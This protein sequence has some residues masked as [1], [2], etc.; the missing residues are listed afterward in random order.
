MKLIPFALLISLSPLL[1]GQT[2]ADPASMQVDLAEG[3]WQRGKN[4]YAAG[5][6][7]TDIE[8]RISYFTRAAQLF[9]EFQQR[10]PN[11]RE[12]RSAQ[13]YQAL[14]LYNSGNVDAA[15]AIFSEIITTQRTGPY[16]AAASSAMAGDAFEKKDYATAAA[17][18]AKLAANAVKPADRQRGH[19]FEALSHHYRQRER[20]ALT[21]YRKV[22]QDPDA[23]QSP[24]LHLCRNAV[25]ALLLK[26][27]KS[28]EAL[29]Y[30]EEI[31]RSAAPEKSRAEATFYAGVTCLQLQENARAE[32]Y[33]QQ[34]LSQSQ[35]DWQLYR[36]DALTSLMQ[37]RFQEKKY[38][39][40]VRLFRTHPLSTGDE[41]QAKRT[42]LAARSFMLIGSY[43]EAIPLFLDVQK[44]APDTKLA[45][46]ASYHRL[47]CFYQ[48]DGKHIVEQVDAF[49]EIY[50]KSHKS[51]PRLHAALMMK[52][53]A[54][55]NQGKLA[56]AAATY[57]LIDT[58]LIAENNRA[59]LQYQRGWCL[60]KVKNYQA[61]I[62]SLTQFISDHPQDKRR[63][64]AM[65]LRGDCYLESGDRESALKEFSQLIASEPGETLASY[66]WQK[67]AIVKKQNND[68]PGMIASYET[69]L[70]KFPSL[71]PA[72]VANAAFYIGYG[73]H[74][75]NQHKSAISQLL[76]AREMDRKTYGRRAGLLLISCYYQTEQI[77]PL[78]EEIDASME[79]GYSDQISP[80]LV[81]WA[82]LQSLNQGKGEQ[83]ARFFMLI[84]NP[85]EPRRTPR[86]VW[87]NLAKAQILC[88][89]YERSL[90]AIEHVLAVEEH[91]QAQADALLDQARCYLAL[92]KLTE[93]R[94]SIESCFQHK[95]QGALEAEASIVFGDILMAQK[96]PQEAQKRFA[97]VALLIE[98]ARLKPLA[99]SRLIQA[100]EANQDF[101]KAAEYRKELQQ[102]FPDWKEE[103]K[104]TP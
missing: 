50:E 30:F 61:A 102:Q 67:T 70:Q 20:E 62:R 80:A 34:I 98:D 71:P 58:S 99:I 87:R 29:P 32:G 69:L 96:L 51:H 31:L 15:K 49:L 2:P 40:V 28:Q 46:D 12:V 53:G 66:A 59:N 36:A 89:K 3:L 17:L 85:D 5:A 55:Q 24:Y 74:K 57:E 33:F 26:E 1:L 21:A 4:L 97:G 44:L 104:P 41:R 86:E 83:A 78:C 47:L 101:T 14:C 64:E 25:G 103:A 48:I 81:S 45:F 35:P 23:A 72:T 7:Q 43:L 9:V 88:Q 52:A 100:L 76:R 68:L 27:G 75:Q 38:S 22:L 82:G 37:L 18:Y 73:Q 95:P 39:E 79:Q 93:A 54:L 90:Q 94:K 91:P 56:E 11:H 77:N 6:N 42:N 92:K 65:A 84:A 63:A 8:Q 10:Y 19:Y 16:V 60:A 13:Y